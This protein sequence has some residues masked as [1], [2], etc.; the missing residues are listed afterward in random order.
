MLKILRGKKGQSTAEYAIL[1]GIVIAAVVGMQ[2]WVSRGLKG[3]MVDALDGGK[4]VAAVPGLVWPGNIFTTNQF[5]PT[6][7]GYSRTERTSPVREY[8]N[9]S[10][11]WV[12]DMETEGGE[13]TNRIGNQTYTITP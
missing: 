13:I 1:I 3:R 10:N 9:S 7:P 6:V 5:E 4:V 11:Q 12:I 8:F 2:T